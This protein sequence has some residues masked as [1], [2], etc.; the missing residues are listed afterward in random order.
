VLDESIS[1]CLSITLLR[2]VDI[3]PEACA[4]SGQNSGIRSVST[5]EL[6]KPL[7]DHSI[8]RSIDLTDGLRIPRRI[9]LLEAVQLT[10][11]RTLLVMH[12]LLV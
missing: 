2:E 11:Y 1:N 3:A 10:L 8:Q 7:R 6:F 12:Q 5:S 9:G 4:N